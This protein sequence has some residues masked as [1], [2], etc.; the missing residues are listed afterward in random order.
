MML[1]APLQLTGVDEMTKQAGAKASRSVPVVVVASVYV[2]SAL[3]VQVPVTWRDPLTG[4]EGQ[5]APT[6]VRSR[7][8][9]TWRHD[10]V[11]FQA[12][13]RLPPQA[14]T[15]EQDPPCVPPPELPPAAPPVPLAAL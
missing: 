15:L 1:A 3:A 7:S 6:N 12:P 4:A 14:V 2:P 8:P 5:P 10:E 13:T 9:V 11:T